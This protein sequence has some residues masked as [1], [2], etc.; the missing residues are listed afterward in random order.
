M[1]YLLSHFFTICI[2]M[3]NC[4]ISLA[5]NKYWDGGG[6]GDGWSYQ[7]NWDNNTPPAAGDD[8]FIAIGANV[9]VDINV[10]VNSITFFSGSSS[11]L[12][13]TVNF[14]RTLTVTNGITLSHSVP[15]STA[16]GQVIITGDGT[17]SCSSVTINGATSSL[18]LRPLASSVPPCIVSIYQVI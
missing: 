8:I 12:T 17:I 3:L 6:L 14:N 7:D 11:N 4:K 10:T 9:I 5:S 18:K 13:F 1:K 15:L 16:H 2:I